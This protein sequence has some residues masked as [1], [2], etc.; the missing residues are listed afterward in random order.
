MI[1]SMGEKS[2]C[3]FMIVWFDRKLKGVKKED[4]SIHSGGIMMI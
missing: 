2:S 1:Y 4:Q 3:F